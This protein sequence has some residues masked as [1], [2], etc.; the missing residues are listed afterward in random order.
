MRKFKFPAPPYHPVYSYCPGRG[1]PIVPA[2]KIPNGDERHA[3]KRAGG[4]TYAPVDAHHPQGTMLFYWR[5]LTAL[6]NHFEIPHRR[7]H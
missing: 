4:G 5:R 6:S 7:R 1:S 2:G 3:G